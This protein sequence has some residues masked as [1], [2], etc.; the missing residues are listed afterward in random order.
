M[1]V[2]PTPLAALLAAVL[3]TATL[4]AS[5]GEVYKWVDPAGRTHYSDMPRPGWERVDLRGSNAVA[6]ATAPAAAESADGG[7]SGEATEAG[8]DTAAREQ[9]RAEE[10]QRAKDQ[11]AS[12]Q[13]APNIVER[14]ALGNEKEY[15]SEERLQLLERTQ[16]RVD[17]YCGTAQ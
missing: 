3:A 12:Y 11:L 5:A 9:L 15:S 1:D 8:T 16:K 17:E 10:C 4:G 6:N 7:E 13:R 2:K 14:D